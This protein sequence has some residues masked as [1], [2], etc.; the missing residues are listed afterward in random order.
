[1]DRA[2]KAC[3]SGS[4]RFATQKTLLV[5]GQV[6][7]DL[8]GDVPA[9]DDVAV[10]N[11]EQVPERAPGAVDASLGQREDEV[12]LGDDAVDLLVVDAFREPCGHGV[13]QSVASVADR[14]VVRGFRGPA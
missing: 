10:L 14:G 8:L 3:S 6:G 5:W 7:G 12:A 4:G 11:A 9:L 1:M 13:A 2:G